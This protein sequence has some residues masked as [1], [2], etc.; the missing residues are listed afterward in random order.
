M[1]FLMVVEDYRVNGDIVIAR[2]SSGSTVLLAGKTSKLH[3]K[4]ELV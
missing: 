3:D 2:G 4:V 1:K